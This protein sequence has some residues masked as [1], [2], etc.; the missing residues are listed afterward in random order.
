MAHTTTLVNAQQAHQTL[1]SL[2]NW[3]KPRL[4]DGH[5]LTISV[6]EA[7]RSSEQNAKLH[8][9]LNEIA[10]QAKWAG[11]KWD[12][13]VWKRLLTAAWMRTRGEQLVMLP[14]LDGHGVDIVFRRTSSL[15]K[16]E[17]SDLLEYVIA[18]AAQNGVTC[19]Q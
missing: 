4:M 15:S 17:C 5:R 9:T 3:A 14:A 19:A 11:Q 2:W 10:R 8:A 13:E 18:W 6:S 16:A 12:A 1:Q 7:T